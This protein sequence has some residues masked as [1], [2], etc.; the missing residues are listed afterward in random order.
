MTSNHV[1]M[2]L[3]DLYGDKR[4]QKKMEDKLQYESANLDHLL[5]LSLS[6]HTVH[7]II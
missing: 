5:I 7:V 3:F 1:L 4:A 6:K 2:F